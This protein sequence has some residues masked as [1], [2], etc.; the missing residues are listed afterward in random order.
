MANAWSTASLAPWPPPGIT[1]LAL[2]TSWKR[3]RDRA[4]LRS[5]AR[6]CDASCTDRTCTGSV[7]FRILGLSKSKAA[8]CGIS[9]LSAQLEVHLNLEHPTFKAAVRRI[10][11]AC[12]AHG[13]L[14]RG[15][16]E[17]EA[18]IEEYWQLRCKVLNRRGM[19]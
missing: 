14:A 4:S 18:Q 6:R 1:P 5:Q 16:A 11:A 7:S 15:L 8:P 17:T 3:L 10:A 9:D 19:M 2:S 12:N 13:K